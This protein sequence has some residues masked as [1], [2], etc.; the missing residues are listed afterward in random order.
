MDSKAYFNDKLSKLLFVNL[1]K[2]AV[3][4]IF[5]K[6]IECSIPFPINSLQVLKDDK[7]KLNDGK[8]S[9]GLFIEGMFYILGIDEQFKYND[10][11]IYLL[12]DSKNS[13]AFIKGKIASLIKEKYYEEAYIL[14]NGLT[15]VEFNK[16]N[17]GKLLYVC[18]LLRSKNDVFEDEEIKAIER[19]KGISDF[20]DCYYYEAQIEFEKCNSDKAFICINEYLRRGGKAYPEVNELKNAIEGAINLQKGKELLTSDPKKA[21]LYLIPL[22]NKDKGNVELL[23]YV[24]VAYRNLE[25]HYKAIYYLNQALHLDNNYAD[26]VNELGINYSCIGNYNEAIKYF[27]KAFSVT[28]SIEICTN[29]VMCYYN[30]GDKKQARLH[31]DIAE[32][33]NPKDEVVLKLEKLLK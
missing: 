23:Y 19:G 13:I 14:L 21:L 3:H 33:L 4:S 20:P 30:I 31:L 17:M 7:S 28:H 26:V 24:A 10:K 32:K 1:K 2:E 6:D 12:K 5:E 18:N 27:R 16:D 25:D 22:M 9:A 8:I 11:Y 29:L 15:Y